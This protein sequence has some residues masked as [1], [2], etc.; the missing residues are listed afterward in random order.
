MRSIQK[1]YKHVTTCS[2]FKIK[3]RNVFSDVF[4][5]KTMVYPSYKYKNSKNILLV[6]SSNGLQ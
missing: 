4:T 2:Q 6:T 5:K 1:M 3:I